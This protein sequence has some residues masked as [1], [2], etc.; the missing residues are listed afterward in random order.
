VPFVAVIA[1]LLD[2]WVEK[3]IQMRSKDE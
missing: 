1:R 2:D 3:R